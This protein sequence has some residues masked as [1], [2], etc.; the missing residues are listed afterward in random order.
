MCIRDRG[1]GVFQRHAD[2]LALGL[3]GRLADRLRNFLGFAL[4]ETDTAFLIAYD[5]KCSKAKAFAAL[6]GLRHPVDRD[7]AVS[8]LRGFFRPVIAAIIATTIVPT[9]FTFCHFSTPQNLS[10][11]HI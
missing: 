1:A 7:Q 6:D 8:E 9:V 2:K 4:A 5:H 10:L 3:L 11:I